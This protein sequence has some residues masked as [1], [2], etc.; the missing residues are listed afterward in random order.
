MYQKYDNLTDFYEY[1]NS[2]YNLI[3]LIIQTIELKEQKNSILFLLDCLTEEIKYYSYN[4]VDK[5]D[6]KK[7]SLLIKLYN[8][9]IGR[10]LFQEILFENDEKDKNLVFEKIKNQLFIIFSPIKVYG[11]YLDSSNLDT[12][13]KEEMFKKI[14]NFILNKFNEN[15]N[16]KLILEPFKE[17]I[18]TLINPI[19][20]FPDYNLNKIDKLINNNIDKNSS[21]EE[22]EEI[23]GDFNNEKDLNNNFDILKFFIE[24]IISANENKHELY[25]KKIYKKDNKVY[26]KIYLISKKRKIKNCYYR[27]IFFDLINDLYYSKSQRDLNTIISTIFIPLLKLYNENYEKEKSLSL[28][29]ME[30]LSFLP[31][32]DG[33][34]TKIIEYS[35]KLILS[36]DIINEN[37]NLNNIFKSEIL[38]FELYNKKYTI[39]SYLLKIIL[40]IF[41]FFDKKFGY[42]KD[43]CFDKDYA[44]WEYNSNEENFYLNKYYSKLQNILLILNKDY[45]EIIEKAANSLIPYFSE[46]LN[47]N[48]YLLIPFEIFNGI[49]YFIKYFFNYAFLYRKLNFLNAQN[50]ND[51]I[52]LFI[53]FSLKL[54]NNK[55]INEKKYLLNVIE[56]IK[57]IF[58]LFDT[59]IDLE[60]EEV[61]EEDEEEDEDN[62]KINKKNI[63]N[64]FN[65]KDWKILIQSIKRNFD[66]NNEKLIEKIDSFFINYS[67][68]YY[69]SNNNFVISNLINYIEEDD[70]LIK[71]FLIDSCI[72]RGVIKNFSKILNIN[73]DN[74]DE[75]KIKDLEY[76]YNDLL[77]SVDCIN[78]YINIEKLTKKYLNNYI[79]EADI[80]IDE[81]EK[82]NNN[83]ERKNYPIYY[84]FIKMTSIILKKIFK[85]KYFQTTKTLYFSLNSYYIKFYVKETIKASILIMESIII[86]IPQNYSDF[87]ENEKEKSKKIKVKKK[88]KSLKSKNIIKEYY[89]ILLENIQKNDIANLIC[90]L[91]K[92]YTKIKIDLTGN[93]NKLKDIIIILDNTEKKYNLKEGNELEEESNSIILC[94]I[95]FDNNSDCHVSP[96][97]HSFC[98]VCIQKFKNN[99]CPLCRKKLNGVFE[100]PKFKFTNENS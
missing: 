66:E 92:Y 45:Y 41:Y 40:N 69:Y 95:C 14:D 73:F 28:I 97:G 62:E 37:G 70:F 1:F 22:N 59:L 55:Y 82:E 7:W 35:T 98:M 57:I 50:K 33:E 24:K 89:E 80:N 77:Y 8:F 83:L 58:N 42:Y 72:K 76:L 99:L 61:E 100:F 56:N 86:S 96:C 16:P 49:Q 87:L 19:L 43:K 9:F 53:K 79:N 71:N 27:E 94:P 31:L 44:F 25:L 54:L 63:N 75:N 78:N 30:F 2:K 65:D 67:S 74:L 51:L 23:E 29:N 36:K 91:E 18:K 5:C 38:N 10:K 90:L 17:L 47:N 88:T 13:S 68:D 26:D 52:L 46:L 85:D 93:L 11:I 15:I 12:L 6:F 4:Y 39:S 3:Y 48:F 64:F 34:K 84:F 32:I 20:E 81:E 21:E 60:N